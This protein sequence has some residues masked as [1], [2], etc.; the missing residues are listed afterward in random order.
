MPKSLLI[1][2]GILFLTFAVLLS[3]CF[4]QPSNTPEQ[5]AV[6]TGTKVPAAAA[7]FASPEPTS[8]PT[9]TPIPSPTPIPWPSQ[10]ITQENAKEIKEINRWGRGSPLGIQRLKRD[11]D[12]F[13]V[14]TSFGLYLYQMTD[15]HV[16]AFFPDVKGAIISQDESLIATSL[17]NGD[18]QIWSMDD[19]SLKQTITHTFPDDI[20]QKI[21]EEHLLPYYVGGMAFSPD[22]SEIAVGYA[23][24]DVALYRLGEDDPYLTLRHDSFSL[25]QTDV[26]LVFQLS[27]SPD[28]KTLVV[29]KYEPY[30][31]ANRLTFWSLTDGELISVSE[32]GR[33]YEFAEP[34]Y[35]PDGQTL[36]VFS[37]YDS[38]LY[39]TT[40]DIRTGTQLSRFDTD[41]VEIIST[42]LTADGGQITIYGRDAQWTYFRQVRTLPQG[43][44]IENEKLE[45]YPRQ[46]YLKRIDK[47]LFEQGHYANSWVDK[48]TIKF[49]QL[50]VNENETFR[51]LGEDNWLMFP[52]GVS[53]PLNLPEDASN[54]YY[55]RQE[56]TIGWCTKGAL[57]FIDKDGKTTTMEVPPITHCD[58]VIVSPQRSYALVWYGGRSMHMVNLKTG[59]FNRLSAPRGWNM[60]FLDARFSSDEEILVTSRPGSVAVWQ[61]DPLQKLADTHHLGMA[62]GNNIKVVIAKDKSFAVTLNSADRTQSDPSHIR[63]WRIEDV[64]PLHSITPSFRGASQPE[65]TT[66]VLSPDDKLIASGD[67]FGGISLWSVKSG[68]ET[69]YF[70][71][72]V[73][74]VDMAFT[75][76]G[77]GLLIVLDDGT[78]RLWG[79]P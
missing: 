62:A 70:D 16:L 71:I 54:P 28:G 35:L 38:Y 6:S 68:E 21:E 46:E 13:F 15:P 79:I 73:L 7:E 34:A 10:P 2:G 30:V 50:G 1:R 77:S 74:P 66:F 78:V 72:D 39:L 37:R 26:G 61:V 44:W 5:A 4:S 27:Y 69:A 29:F 55:D 49:A 63:V 53:E 48:D 20:V 23:D 8:V 14:L 40:R 3:S 22:T 17:K 36:L 43:D 42:E 12:Q 76:N 24:G 9:D 19:L 57:H 51:V 67:E 47:F 45:E 65:F 18:I 52:E 58:A 64:F 60:S 56:Q 25:W 11:D 41:L 31:N 75:P 59:K 33:F 32:A